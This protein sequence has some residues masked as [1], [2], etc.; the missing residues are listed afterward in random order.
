[1][2]VLLIIWREDYYLLLSNVK[3]NYKKECQNQVKPNDSIYLDI[4]HI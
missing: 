3:T 2:N 4:F 1:M